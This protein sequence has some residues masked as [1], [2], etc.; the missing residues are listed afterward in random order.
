MYSG[1]SGSGSID[2]AA[3]G[4][5]PEPLCGTSSGFVPVTATAPRIPPSAWPG[6]EQMYPSPSAGTTTSPV[7]V[8]PGVGDERRS[9]GE[10]D[11]VEDRPVVHERDRVPT[12]CVD[13]DARRVEAKVERM[14]HQVP[15]HLASARIG[16]WRS[17]RRRDGRR[18]GWCGRRRAGTQC[19]RTEDERHGEDGGTAAEG[20]E[21][22]EWARDGHDGLP[23][24]GNV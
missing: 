20:E 15:E 8:S 6:I 18:A 16:G 21:Q 19:E 11:V 14:E 24:Q 12:R 7:T 9:I 22:D 1:A 23:E 3:A 2:A 4:A 5:P 10:R 17:A 13:L